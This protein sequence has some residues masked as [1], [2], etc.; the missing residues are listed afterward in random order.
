MCP[1]YAEECAADPQRSYRCSGCNSEGLCP[2]TCRRRQFFASCPAEWQETVSRGRTAIIRVPRGANR[3]LPQ[4]GPLPIVGAAPVSG[5]PTRL[6]PAPT[7]RWPATTSQPQRVV[8]AVE[9]RAAG[10]MEQLNNGPRRLTSRDD[11]SGSPCRVRA[12]ECGL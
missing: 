8:Q 2:S 5:Q 11:S 6:P 9:Q 12:L 1:K 4:R 3:D 10:G 7:P